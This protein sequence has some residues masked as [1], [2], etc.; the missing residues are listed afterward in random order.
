MSDGRRA[1][2]I[3]RDGTIIHDPGY[4]SDPMGVTLL[5][6]AV[7]G[8]RALH[9]AGLLL[10]LVSN[11]AGIGRG[12]YDERALTAVHERLAGLLRQRGVALDAAYY[13]PHAP[14]DRCGCRKPQPG[15]LMRAEEELGVDLARSWMVGDNLS[16]IGAGFSAGCTTIL[17]ADDA[18]SVAL[19]QAL[20]D[21]VMPDLR[22]A[23]RWIV[24]H[25]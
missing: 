21:V 15:M 2:L 8:L 10:V 7:E 6:G 22:A 11:Q 14:W 20:P 4:L 12:Y 5:P 1:A 13:C 16:D 24:R 17:L 18:P 9:D 25:L 3:D 23:A 19:E